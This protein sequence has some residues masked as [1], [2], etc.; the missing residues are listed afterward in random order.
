MTRLEL[1]EREINYYLKVYRGKT[2]KYQEL[3]QELEFYKNLGI[4]IYF[5]KILTNGTNRI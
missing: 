4:I 2:D 1:L 3:I 5:N